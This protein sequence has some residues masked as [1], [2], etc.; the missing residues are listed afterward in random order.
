MRK[1]SFF[2]IS[3]SLFFLASSVL[4]KA[5]VPGKGLVFDG[6]DDYVNV[7]T[8]TSDELNPVD[9]LTLECWV[10]LN[11]IPSAT[12]NPHLISRFNC[13]SLTVG[14]NGLAT[15]YLQNDEGDWF[16]K[17]GTTWPPH[18]MDPIFVFLSTGSRKA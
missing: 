13:Y 10:Y 6:D 5:Q 9:S 7:N 4:L 15:A 11:E 12:H 17:A 18:T 1:I 14:A 3:M 2:T 16:S 8:T